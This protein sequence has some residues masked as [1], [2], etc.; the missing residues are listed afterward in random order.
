MIISCIYNVIFYVHRSRASIVVESAVICNKTNIS[1]MFSQEISRG[2]PCISLSAICTAN[3]KVS[4]L[5]PESS[6]M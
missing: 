4:K 3:F 5:K 2:P 6:R 1:R